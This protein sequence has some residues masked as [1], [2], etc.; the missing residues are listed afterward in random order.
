MLGSK[1][2]LKLYCW[3]S[4]LD[5]ITVYL[6]TSQ[7]RAACQC[8]ASAGF[9][10]APQ[11]RRS[12]SFCPGVG[13]L[14]RWSLECWCSSSWR[15]TCTLGTCPR[16]ALFFLVSWSAQSVTHKG[17]M[18]DITK[19]RT[20]LIYIHYNHNHTFTSFIY[21]FRHSHPCHDW[22]SYAWLKMTS[23]FSAEMKI[24]MTM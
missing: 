12:S 3:R 17:S 5:N 24:T 6:Q 2:K 9:C 15:I 16:I 11:R 18:Q 8:G 21:S 23:K 7:A 1:F 20:K 22:Y 14:T 4:V 10:I 19:Y 13:D